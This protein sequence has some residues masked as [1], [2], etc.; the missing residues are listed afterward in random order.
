[1]LVALFSRG[2]MG[3]HHFKSTLQT[4]R[5]ILLAAATAEVE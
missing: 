2:L 3:M 5:K 4:G 1:M